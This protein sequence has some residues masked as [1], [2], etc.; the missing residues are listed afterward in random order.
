M[1]IRGCAPIDSDRRFFNASTENYDAGIASFII[2]AKY[3]IETHYFVWITDLSTVQTVNKTS[4]QRGTVIATR[5]VRFEHRII[6]VGTSTHVWHTVAYDK[7][8]G[9]QLMSFVF[10]YVRM[11]LKVRRPIPLDVQSKELA[12]AYFS[13]RSQHQQQ[14]PAE[15]MSMTSCTPQDII[16]SC[17]KLFSR[18]WIVERRNIDA[19][20]H[21]NYATYVRFATNTLLEWL[22]Q[23]ATMTSKCCVVAEEY[24]FEGESLLGD[25]LSVSLWASRNATARRQSQPAHHVIAQVNVNR[26]TRVTFAR[27]ILSDPENE[28]SKA[29]A[30]VG[31]MSLL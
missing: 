5:P 20:N 26:N 27:F 6:S 21:A 31:P 15:L 17:I 18:R 9:A 3:Y 12:R 24:L 2:Y 13:S 8:S 30:T 10:K 23:R 7:G 28:L 1:A 22:S 4:Q 16:E 14:P 25:E 29:T 11:D 19:N